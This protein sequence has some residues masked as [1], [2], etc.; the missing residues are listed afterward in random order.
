MPAKHKGGVIE[1]GI[2]KETGLEEKEEKMITLS[3]GKKI[4]EATVIEALKS[5]TNQS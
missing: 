1:Y 4:S 3:N 5:L 2:L